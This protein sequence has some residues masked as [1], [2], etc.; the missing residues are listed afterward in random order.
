[1]VKLAVL[2]VDC[3]L[4]WEGVRRSWPLSYQVKPSGFITKTGSCGTPA[5]GLSPEPQQGGA[6][7]E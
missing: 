3:L 7:A 6:E 2:H 5:P 1:M 4:G